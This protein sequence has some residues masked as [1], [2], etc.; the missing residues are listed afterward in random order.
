MAPKPEGPQDELQKRTL[1]AT[2]D[3]FTIEKVDRFTGKLICYHA[4]TCAPV[5]TP[6]AIDP[7]K[8]NISFQPGSMKC[9]GKHCS[10]WNP[11]ELECFD[12]TAARAA[13]S[14]V[15]VLEYIDGHARMSS[16]K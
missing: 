13:V 1:A 5:G 4:I 3:L 8:I 2:Q 12:N 6:D 15:Q 9:V 16:E 10:R 14:T 11:D 7:N